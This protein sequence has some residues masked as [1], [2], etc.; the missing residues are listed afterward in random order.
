[1]ADKTYAKLVDESVK[2]GFAGMS[3]ELR[4]NIL[5]FYKGGSDVASS[6]LQRNLEMLKGSTAYKMK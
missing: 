1:M 2:H 6:V 5:D 3:Q 4:Q